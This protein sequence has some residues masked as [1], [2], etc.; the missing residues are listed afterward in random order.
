M[1]DLH[2]SAA[3]EPALEA[4]MPA[5]AQAI[6]GHMARA[7]QR[8]WAEVYLR[9]LLTTRGR[10]SVRRIA[11]TVSRSPTAAM[12]LQQF[13]NVS[14]WEWAPTRRELTRLAERGMNP[15]AWTI[16]NAILPKRGD[17]SCGVH[18]RFVPAVG[19]S[20]NCQVG[21]GV[22]LSSDDMAIPVD[23]RLLLPEEWTEDPGKRLRARIPEALGCR[24]M[25]AQVLNLVDTLASRTTR[26]RVPVVADMS[27]CADAEAFLHGLSRRGHQFVVAVRPAL[28]VVGATGEPRR[29][30]SGAAFP[31]GRGMATALD[32]VRRPGARQWLAAGE[33]RHPQAQFLSRPVGLPGVG[34]TYRIFSDRCP[35]GAPS[36]RVWITNLVDHHID[37]LMALSR[38]HSGTLAALASLERDFGLVDFEGRSF[39]GWHHHMTLT[40]AAY[41]YSR[42]SRCAGAGG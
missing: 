20:I 19:R 14:P 4:T 32:V 7:D 30:V 13:V 41:A 22:F 38:L 17:Y 3:L 16:G 36:P 40:S 23:W 35:E 29:V 34:H 18:R 42:L 11:A 25:W 26:P 2:G 39:P 1:A 31:R 28:Q 10:K 27:E 5:F 9:G 21:T 15:R 6:F 12:S 37:H 33:G 8:R 24:P